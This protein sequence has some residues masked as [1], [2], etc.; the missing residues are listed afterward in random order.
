[1]IFSIVII[2][3]RKKKNEYSNR[4]SHMIRSKAFLGAFLVF[5][6]MVVLIAPDSASAAGLV[7]C[8]DASTPCTLCHFIQGISNIIIQVRNLMVFVGLTVITAMGIVYIVSGGNEKMTTIAKSG[9]KTTLI[10][11]VFVLFAW[12]IVNMVMFYIFQA[13]DD[14]GVDVTF[15]FQSKDDLGV[16]GFVFNCTTGSRV[17]TSSAGSTQDSSSGL[18][19]GRVATNASCADMN[20]ALMADVNAAGSGVPA[21]L[22]VA[23]M[24]RE[25]APALTNPKACSSNNG[26]GAGGPMQFLQSTW[27]DYKCTGSRFVRADALKCAAKKISRDSGGNY[28]D[29]GITKAAKAYCGRCNDLKACGGDY[30]DGII[31]NYNV[32]KN[33]Q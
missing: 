29:A 33:C 24:R 17:G 15:R 27:D 7:P 32:Y 2:S 22:L 6:T 3:D 21:A 8:G 11:I 1:M 28:S 26:S 4:Y 31:A 12:F 13:K 5:L 30:C 14:L 9:I 23:F 10:G 18:S 16:D 19:G 20:E 25:C